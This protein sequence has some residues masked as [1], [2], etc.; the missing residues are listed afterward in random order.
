MLVNTFVFPHSIND[1]FYFLCSF[2]FLPAEHEEVCSY[3]LRHYLLMASY[4]SP[5]TLL[6]FYYLVIILSPTICCSFW[7]EKKQNY[8][9][10]LELQLQKCRAIPNQHT[11]ISSQSILPPVTT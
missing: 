6:G 10:A 2:L 9:Y 7:L 1:P 11:A 4:P 3:M 5:I 8:S